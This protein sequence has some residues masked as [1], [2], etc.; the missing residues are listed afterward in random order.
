VRNVIYR[1]IRVNLARRLEKGATKGALGNPANGSATGLRPP[2][3]DEL[4]AELSLVSTE[5]LA[6]QRTGRSSPLQQ[7]CQRQ[8]RSLATAPKP[9]R[10]ARIIWPEIALAAVLRIAAQ[11]SRPPSPHP[12]KGLSLPTGIPRTPC[13]NPPE[14][15]ERH[16][17]ITLP[18]PPRRPRL[19]RAPY[20]K[21]Q[22]PLGHLNRTL[23]YPAN[24][25]P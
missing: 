1:D 21:P 19:P 5:S 24:A 18:H 23:P 22:S 25:P 2:P 6:P 12:P 16:T 7:R 13:N 10:S 9:V 17:L 20:A 14:R 11:A 4:F 3:A 8:E 15:N